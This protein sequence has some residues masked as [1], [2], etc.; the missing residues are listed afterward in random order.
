MPGVIS[1]RISNICAQLTACCDGLISF[2]SRLGLHDD[3]E[4]AAVELCDELLRSLAVAT[5]DACSRTSTTGEPGYAELLRAEVES[6]LADVTL[7]EDEDEEQMV[8]YA[9]SDLWAF[10]AMASMGM[11][12]GKV[13]VGGEGMA[14]VGC[15]R[16]KMVGAG[17]VLSGLLCNGGH[18][19]FQVGT[20]FDGL[21]EGVRAT[22]CELDM[23]GLVGEVVLPDRAFH[24]C[25][26]LKRIE[27]PTGLSSV[28]AYAFADCRE[29]AFVDLR[30]TNAMRL[31]SHAFH[32]CTELSEILLPCVLESLG[33]GCLSCTGVRRLDLRVTRCTSIEMRALRECRAC[34]D[35]FVPSCLQRLGYACCEGSGLECVDLSETAVRVIERGTFR[36]CG[37]LRVLNL[38]KLL[39]SVA[40]EW[41][42][43]ASLRLLDFSRTQVKRLNWADINAMWPCEREVLLPR[44]LEHLDGW[45]DHCYLWGLDVYVDRLRTGGERVAGVWDL[46]RLNLR[47]AAWRAGCWTSGNTLL[48]SGCAGAASCRAARPLMPAA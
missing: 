39:D 16:G 43:L 24:D 17:L 48:L 29:L 9:L 30:A 19:I 23:Q 46:C 40:D 8:R 11:R 44:V 28:G 26:S 21:R 3:G 1:E 42:T 14:K 15:E 2:A 13:R 36:G 4:R 38:P 35:L 27:W 5:A 7:K 25:R 6:R 10:V 37:G 33:E 22:L 12:M 32:G 31:G 20:G 41:L 18:V 34:H 47:G 45:V